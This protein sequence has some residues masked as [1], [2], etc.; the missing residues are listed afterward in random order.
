LHYNV[1]NL[2]ANLNMR[3]WVPQWCFWFID[4]ALKRTGG[5]CSMK[6]DWFAGRGIQP[7]GSPVVVHELC[8]NGLAVSDHDPI[9]LPFQPWGRIASDCL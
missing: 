1:A 8:H 7:A 6:L 3:E 4:W 5:S 2:A 9:V